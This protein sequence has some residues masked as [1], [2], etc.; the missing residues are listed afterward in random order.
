M[1]Q[2]PHRKARPPQ[3]MPKGST[4]WRERIAGNKVVISAGAI[5]FLATAAAFNRFAT[6][7]A[8]ANNPPAGRFIEV[9]GVRLHYVERGTGT[10]VVLLHGNGVMLQDFIASGVFDRVAADHR[11]IAFDRPGFGYS[12]RPRT[13]IWTPGA[14]A[15]LLAAALEKLGVSNAVVVGH[16]WGTMVV[17]AMALDHPGRVAGL[18]LLSGYYYGT[19]RP[20]VLPAS[21]P[22][23][24]ILGDM[25]AHTISPLTGA[26]IGPIGI[27][28]SFAPAPVSKKFADVPLA[29]ALR[30]SQIRAT[31]ADTAMMIPGA[32]ALSRRYGELELPVTIIAGEGDQIAHIDNHACKLAGELSQSVLEIVPGQGHLFHY[33]VPDQVAAAVDAVASRG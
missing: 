11:V 5:G 18:V 28:A 9:D 1:T 6:H 29:L 21:T 20:D 30:P 32:I 19:A 4:S 26:M 13:T 25:M 10:P 33:A 8:E 12:D 23:I 31:A 22:A 16:S 7:R 14:Q 17:L 27:K 3:S 24:P 15:A 2:K